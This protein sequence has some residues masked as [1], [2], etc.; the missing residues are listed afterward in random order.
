MMPDAVNL[1]RCYAGQMPRDGWYVHPSCVLL[2][3]SIDSWPLPF[4][5]RGIERRALSLT[6]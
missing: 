4:I 5:G 2:R 6:S 3:R 1:S